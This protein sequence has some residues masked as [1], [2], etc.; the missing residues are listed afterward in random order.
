MEIHYPSEQ[1]TPKYSDEALDKIRLAFI[2]GS[3]RSGT[4]LLS[5]V[6][7]AHQHVSVCPERQ[8]LLFFGSQFKAKN[9][10]SER[11]YSRLKDYFFI[12]K[13]TA[14]GSI[15]QFN[16]TFFNKH[17]TLNNTADF[18]FS[19]FAKIAYLSQ[20]I[21]SKNYDEIHYLIDKNP[22]YSSNV[23]LLEKTVPKGKFVILTRDYR[24]HLKSYKLGQSANLGNR[25]LYFYAIIWRLQNISLRKRRNRENFLFVRYEDFVSQPEKSLIDICTFLDFEYHSDLLKFNDDLEISNLD[26]GNTQNSQAQSRLKHKYTM[27]SKPINADNLGAWRSN[28][29][30]EE[31]KMA[32]VICGSIGSHYDYQKTHSLSYMEKLLILLKGSPAILHGILYYFGTKYF[33]HSPAFLKNWF[34]N[35]L[36]NKNK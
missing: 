7:N 33:F 29:T 14:H 24:D 22:V 34:L 31:V 25:S 35:N 17:F 26:S 12:E 30:N 18:S 13:R 3:P 16:G 11:D 5:T 4:T 10:L 15:W 36:I 6:L 32:E 9:N 23:Q 1:E 19:R 21:P 2:S 8:F 27:L 20:Q 28:L